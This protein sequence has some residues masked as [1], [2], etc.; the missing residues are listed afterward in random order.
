MEK[1]GGKF[2]K[3]FPGDLNYDSKRAETLEIEGSFDKK[4]KRNLKF[5]RSS[6]KKRRKPSKIREVWDKI[7]GKTFNLARHQSIS[8]PQS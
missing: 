6:S 4:S 2:L 3:I 1:K 7:S 5:K 8:I